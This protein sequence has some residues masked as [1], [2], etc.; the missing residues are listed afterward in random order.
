M[1]KSLHLLFLLISTGFYGQD[2]ALFTQL[3]GRYD[4]TFAGN[5]LNPQEN[6]FM[7]TPTILTESSASLT[8]NPDDT[9]IAAYLYWAG[10]GT[11]DF[12]V[13][14]NGESVSAT[15]TFAYQRTTFNLTLD[16][17]SAFADVTTQIQN[18]G[19]GTYTLQGLDVSGFL[20]SHF[21]NRTNFAGWALLVV[22]ENESLPLNQLNIYDGLQAVPSQINITL[23]SLNVIDNQD[24]KIG[25]LAWEGDVDLAANER[26]RINTNALSND[27]NPE[28][29]AFNGTNSFTGSDTLYNMDLDVYLIENNIEIGD[30]AAQIQITSDWDMVMVNVVVTKLN[31]QLPDATVVVDNIGLL[32][33]SRTVTVSF[34]VSNFNS[35]DVLPSGTPISIYADGIFVQYTETLAPIA[36]GASASDAVSFVLPEGIP[37]DFELQIVVD[38][39]G[40]GEGI[41]TEIREDNN[42]DS[43]AVSLLIPPAINPLPELKACNLGGGAGIFDFSNYAALATGDE[44]ASVTF[45]DSLENAIT[46]TAAI[47]DVSAYQTTTPDT[48]FVR[49]EDEFGCVS[50]SSFPLTVRNCPPVVYNYV[51]PNLDGTN[52]SFHIDGL[53]GI[54]PRFD[55]RIFN[56]WGME[57]WEG[58]QDSAEWDGT[59]TKGILWNGSQV[60]SGTYYYV[61]HLYDPDYPQPLTGWLFL[62]RG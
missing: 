30:S 41:V 21:Q 34:T 31:S 58:N 45:Y 4:F 16:Y 14:L 15:R 60:P 19:N 5:T 35:T 54:F 52:D 2:V 42:T 28:E 59:A 24:A 62:S 32:C 12:A 13:S 33:D 22:Y 36:I 9:I 18:T 27:L 47:V 7:V 11:G 6:S 8:L 43:L 61:I 46:G 38:D 51:S 56:R 57:V 20:D 55:I 26:L 3:N 44:L 1:K 37:S 40:N 29:N 23:N 39:I 25:F 53:Y 48:I 10:C 17:F 50:T 49:V